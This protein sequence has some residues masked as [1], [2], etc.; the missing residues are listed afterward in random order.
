MVP[1]QSGR[2]DHFSELE[3]DFVSEW[4]QN[5]HVRYFIGQCTL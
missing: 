3:R 2:H 5:I 4:H 1:F